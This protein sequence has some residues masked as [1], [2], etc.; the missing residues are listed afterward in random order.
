MYLKKFFISHNKKMVLSF[1]IHIDN[2]N[3]NKR[4]QNLKADNHLGVFT[5][6]EQK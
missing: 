5:N 6:I 4:I 3:S 2:F 1:E